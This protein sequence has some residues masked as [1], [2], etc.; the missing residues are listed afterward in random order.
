MALNFNNLKNSII[1]LEKSLKIAKVIEI[2]NSD[3]EMFE[4]VRA[5]VIQNFEVCYESAWKAMKRWLEENVEE[6][7]GVTRRALFI[8]GTESKLITDIEKWMLFHRARNSTSHVYEEETAEEV[9][10]IAFEFISYAK[11]LLEKL[12]VR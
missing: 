3:R 10:K 7:D 12:E 5:G 8:K 9:Y 1:S 4:V 6:V 11:E 2:E